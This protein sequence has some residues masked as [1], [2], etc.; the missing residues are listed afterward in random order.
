M[1]ASAA[2][3]I[4]GRDYATK[5]A[6]IDRSLRTARAD[7]ERAA[8][9]RDQGHITEGEFEQAEAAIELL[10]KRKRALEAAEAEANRRADA[11]AAKDR[12]AHRIASADRVADAREEMVDSF[13]RM[14][15]AIA[16][17]EQHVERFV[18]AC[19]AAANAAAAH[20]QV[21][22]PTEIGDLSYPLRSDFSREAGFLM[23]ELWR[24]G[25]S[26]FG[27]GRQ[28]FERSSPKNAIVHKLR[29]AGEIEDR[30]REHDDEG[31]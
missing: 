3:Q 26:K 29:A 11:S 10:E 17:A 30:L 28:V 1:M 13:T 24:A 14:T 9:Q 19:S 15:E 20:R 5:R 22:S 2:P 6:N 18:S 23:G 31:E 12:R 4:A 21:F 27:I 7:L 16:A 25:L 8:Y